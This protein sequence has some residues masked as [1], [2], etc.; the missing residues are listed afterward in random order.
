[1]EAMLMER[2]RIQPS[3]RKKG[4]V[5]LLLSA[6]GESIMSKRPLEGEY[7]ATQVVLLLRN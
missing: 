5:N 7:L 2:G 3:C 4:D 6:D 1:M